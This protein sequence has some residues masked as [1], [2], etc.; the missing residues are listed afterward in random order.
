MSYFWGEGIASNIKTIHSHGIPMAHGHHPSPAADHGRR[1]PSRPPRARSSAPWKRWSRIWSQRWGTRESQMFKDLND[2]LQLSWRWLCSEKTILVGYGCL[3]IV[4][5]CCIRHKDSK[6]LS[7]N[8]SVVTICNDWQYIYIMFT[9]ICYIYIRII[10]W[11]IGFRCIK[12]LIV[13]KH[14]EHEE[15]NSDL[16]W[17]LRAILQS[18]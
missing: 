15:I 7:G 16:E 10:L 9:F 18:K 2:H 6:T 5:T 1:G 4:L 13:I 8:I 11:L 17:E 14:G 12:D 3:N